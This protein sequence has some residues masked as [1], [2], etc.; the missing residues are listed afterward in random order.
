MI[1]IEVAFATAN[2]QCIKT[3]SFEDEE[4]KNLS[5]MQIIHLSDIALEFPDYDFTANNLH[6]GIFGKLIDK[7]LYQL[8]NKDRIEIYRKLILDPNQKRLLRDKIQKNK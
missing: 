8:Q 4:L 6:I 1:K 7:N 5:I 3:L 2:K